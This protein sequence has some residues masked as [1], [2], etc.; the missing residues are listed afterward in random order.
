[1]NTIDLISLHGGHSGQFCSHARDLLEEIIQQYIH[2]GFTRV[3]ITEHVPPI[4]DVFLYPDEKK[5]NFTAL[6]LRK[7]FEA[8]FNEINRLKKLYAPQIRIYAG[9]ETETYTGY[10]DHIRN[11]IK[12]FQPDYMVGSV[13]HVHDICF[14]Y[15]KENYDRVVSMCG[16]IEAL[17]ETYFDLQYEMIKVLKPFVVGH[18]DLVRIFDPEYQKHLVIPAIDSKITR[19]LRLIKSLN[20]VMD[21][22]LRPLA[23]G[24]EEPYITP[25]ILTQVKKMDIPVVPGDDSHGVSEAGRHVDTAIKI[26]KSAGFNTEWPTPVCF[27]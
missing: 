22:N 11:L 9:M 26:L 7:R 8:Y 4:N 3:G 25:L 19:N 21:F 27:E 14:D 16:S 18:F 13:H 2:L 10:V 20:L 12:E 6:D 24:E 23:R 15:S 1:M 17:Y 5:L